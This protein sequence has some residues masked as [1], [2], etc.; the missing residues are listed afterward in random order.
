[1]EGNM[2]KE[3]QR[4]G[5]LVVIDRTIRHYRQPQKWGAKCDCG[6]FRF[7]TERLLKRG[8]CTDC[9]KRIAP[10]ID[11][12]LQALHENGSLSRT[13]MHRLFQSNQTAA[14]I[15]AAPTVMEW[16]GIARQERRPSGGSGRP[17][18][19]WTEACA[20]LDRTIEGG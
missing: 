8:M 9:V 19:V 20:S 15:Q 11:K 18:E 5:R 12:I 16:Q 1:M 17:T 3:G 14:N 10:L 4:F 2:I 7:V 13:Q 6:K